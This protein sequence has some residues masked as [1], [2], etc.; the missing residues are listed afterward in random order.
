M[1][2]GPATLTNGSAWC[3]LPLL[4]PHSMRHYR[5]QKHRLGS[6]MSK[7]DV[8]V[9]REDSQ[10]WG[11]LLQ[12]LACPDYPAPSTQIAPLSRSVPHQHVPAISFTGL[13]SE[14]KP[15]AVGSPRLCAP[16]CKLYAPKA[17]G[18]PRTSRKLLPAPVLSPL[19]MT[20]SE[21]APPQSSHHPP[22]DWRIQLFCFPPK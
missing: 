8:N 20:P 2:K 13:K 10:L 6:D 22:G 19:L 7:Q 18:W 15:E 21:P 3:L 1:A 4:I 14:P 12:Q 9:L 17:Q 11:W 16:I 5:E